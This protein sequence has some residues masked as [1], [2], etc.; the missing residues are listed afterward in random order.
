[1]AIV[2]P[3]GFLPRAR[4]FAGLAWLQGRYR[5]ELSS[6]VFARKGY[7]AGDDSERLASL[8]ERM[9]DPGI[10]AIIAGRGGY[11]ATRIVSSLPWARWAKSPSWI[12]G[13]SDVTALH[14]EAH[15]HGI[16]SVHAPNVTGF[17]CARPLDRLRVMRALEGG[18]LESWP[19]L[20]AVRDGDADGPLVG[21]NLALMFA[22]AAS[23][24]LTNCEGAI[25]VLEDVT[26]KP[27]QVDRML[28]AL[29]EAGLFDKAAAVVFGEFSQCDAGPDG[30]SVAFVIEGFATKIR[31][32]VYS[33]APFGHGTRNEAMILGGK[34][35]LL[36]GVLSVHTRPLARC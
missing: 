25:V 23:G 31:C 19:G 18:V 5:V 8:S 36:R 17:G 13:F 20:T 24:K 1:M 32:P 12:V 22:R 6:A 15:A 3:S 2:A 21:G 11:G 33:G 26:E 14:L 27:Y 10:R 30:V 28:Q 7:F 9:C 4:F 29:L 16:A 34:A 35:S